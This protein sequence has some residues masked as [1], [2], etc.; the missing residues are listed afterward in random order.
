[1]V[2]GGKI[3]NKELGR[4]QAGPG[5]GRDGVTLCKSRGVWG[6]HAGSGEEETN[7]FALQSG[8]R[9]LCRVPDVLQTP[10]DGYECSKREYERGG[11]L[12][13]IVVYFF[14]RGQM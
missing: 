3:G 11:N 12:T 4:I 7:L 13:G 10:V 14:H 9:V 5:P 8:W 6:P 1:V 2:Q